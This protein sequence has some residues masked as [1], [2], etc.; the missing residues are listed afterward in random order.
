[1]LY[2]H[3][4]AASIVWAHPSDSIQNSCL[5]LAIMYIT[6]LLLYS[7]YFL[8][9][10]VLSFPDGTPNCEIGSSST[11]SLHLI[12]ARNP[13]T[14][15]IQ[16]GGFDVFINDVKLVVTTTGPN[17]FDFDAGVD[18]K[19]TIKSSDGDQFRGVLIILS[20]NQ[21][22][23]KE[24]LTPLAPYQDP[25]ACE[26]LPYGGLT[27]SEPSLKSTADGTLRWDT[28]GDIV[29]LDVNIVVV[30]NAVDG[31]VY[32]YTNYKLRAAA[33][34]ESESCGLFGLKLF[35]PLSFCG[36]FGRLLGLCSS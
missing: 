32:Y 30:N 25:I 10:S 4:F 35:C 13:R 23:T 3:I 12:S 5:P 21:T 2:P 11:R 16:V 8:A 22:N 17:I 1:M 27:H 15:Q 6:S 34:A 36:L 18:N 19:L 28:V 9:T 14:G 26:K 7:L 29:S 31:S 20:Q 33:P 24:A